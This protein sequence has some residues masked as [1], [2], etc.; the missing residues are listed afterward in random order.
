MAESVPTIT[1]QPMIVEAASLDKTGKSADPFSSYIMPSIM[2]NSAGTS[3]HG[4]I[5]NFGAEHGRM[6]NHLHGSIGNGSVMG[7]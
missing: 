5:Q 2:M 4:V 6:G 7:Q 1:Q 3:G